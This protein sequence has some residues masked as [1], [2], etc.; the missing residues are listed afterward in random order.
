MYMIHR[1]PHFWLCKNMFNYRY[2]YKLDLFENVICTSLKDNF[3]ML[4]IPIMVIIPFQLH[5]VSY[6]TFIIFYIQA[7]NCN[8]LFIPL[9]TAYTYCFLFLKWQFFFSWDFTAFYFRRTVAC[10]CNCV[11]LNTHWIHWKISK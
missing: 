4:K 5:L 8:H 3:E 6:I 2:L 1:Y 9:P 11:S 10:W 7:L